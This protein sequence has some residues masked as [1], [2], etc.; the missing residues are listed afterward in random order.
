M[1]NSIEVR[2]VKSKSDL[3]KFIKLPW[4]IY[5]DDP[6]WV[7]RLLMDRKKLFNRDKNPFF[8]RNPAEFYIAVRNGEVVGRIAAIVNNEHNEFHNEN[9]GFFGFLE[10]VNDADV[11][12]ALLDSA[13]AWLK[14]KGYDKMM[15]P[16]NPSTNDEV[17]FLLDGYDSPPFMMMQHTPKYYIELMDKLG[18]QKA[19]DLFAYLVDKDS[20]TF[21]QK[22]QRVSKRIER[23]HPMKVRPVNMKD[24]RNELEKVRTIYND[25]W[26]PNW[27]FVPMQKEEFDYVANDFKQI[28]DPRVAL[29]GEYDGEA[30]GFLLA[31]PDYNQVFKKIPSGK[32]LPFGFLTFLTQKKKI[33][34]VRIIILGIKRA[35]QP[36]GLGALFYKEILERAVPIGYHSGEM[37]WILEDN[38][39]MNKSAQLLGG[40]VHKKYRIYESPIS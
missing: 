15:G 24:F 13:K 39:L 28:I 22:L 34:R 18:Y 40:E 20:F 4:K 6:H 17:G 14:E 7:P 31:L 37:S 16:M 11:F 25:A 10:A 12:E 26:E 23:K 19:K 29:I 1:S 32:L 36:H 9:T 33:N 3:M 38:D 27:G 35:Y 21:N 5:K 2:P 30:V 8:K